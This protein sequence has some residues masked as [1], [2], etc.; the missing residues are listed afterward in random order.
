MAEGAAPPPL[1]RPLP[2]WIGDTARALEPLWIASTAALF[3]VWGYDLIPRAIRML[4]HSGQMETIEWGLYMAMLVGFP[5]TCVL[6]AIALPKALKGQ[7]AVVIKAF[8]V[9]VALALGVM[10]LFDGRIFLAAIAL[11]PAIVTALMAPGAYRI[12]S[13]RP[14]HGIVPLVVIG[15]VALIAWMCAGGLVY[16]ARATTWFLSSPVRLIAIVVATVVAITGLPRFGESVE[17]KAA[18]G[19]AFRIA[20]AFVLLLLIVFSFR[21]NPMVEFYHWSFWVG[22]IEQLRQG[23]WL[24]RDTPSQYGFLSILIPAALPGSAWI[25]FWY[26]QAAIYAIVAVL[27]FIIFRRLRGGVGNLFLSILVVFTTLFFRPRSATLILP[28]QMTPSGGP[29]RFL[30]CFVLLGWLLLVFRE[31]KGRRD[32]GA[33]FPLV[34]H[35]IWICSIAWSFEAAIYSSA[36]WFSAFTVYLMQR[37]ADE[38]KEGKSAGAVAAGIVRSV[39]VPVLFLAGLYLL[40]WGI[41]EAALGVAPDL[42]GYT[43]FGLLYSRGFGSLPIDTHGAIWYLLLVFFIAS[44]VVVQFLVDDWRDFR[45]VVAAG[46]WG[47]IWSLSSYFVSRSHPVNLLSITPALLFAVAVLMIVLRHSARRPWHGYVRAATVPVL[48]IPIA[49]TLGHPALSADLS[50]DQLAPHRFTQ[51]IPFMDP[52]LESLLRE[53]GAKPGDPIVRIADGRLMLPAWRGDDGSR[54]LSDRSWLPKPYEIIGSLPPARRQLY[55]ERN[56]SSNTG[57]WLVHNRVNTIANFEE[58]LAEIQRTHAVVREYERGDWI[59]W[60]MKPLAQPASSGHLS[61]R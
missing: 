49:M 14:L 17:V 20:S 38:R 51:Q 61:A 3:V 59:V 23:G 37:G 44:T 60:Y 56:A 7:A 41:Y 1:R 39:L 42:E 25:S 29:V 54:I 43:E 52:R 45:L 30:W 50:T 10:Y 35:I 22:P 15:L 33:G 9:V 58:R 18:P 47:G 19:V 32:A 46:V 21:T 48:A 53:S 34:G 31:A 2:R 6:I 5:A 27:M 57:G 36:I 13:E 26:Y 4:G 11:V 8:A 28:A 40:V 24:L 16:W 55:I 12:V